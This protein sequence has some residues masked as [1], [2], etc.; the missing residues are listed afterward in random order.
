MVTAMVICGHIDFIRPVLHYIL[1]DLS[2]SLASGGIYW[3]VKY[4]HIHMPM[5]N[6]LLEHFELIVL[7][8]RAVGKKAQRFSCKSVCTIE[9]FWINSISININL[10][11]D[12]YC[13]VIWWIIDDRNLCILMLIAFKPH[14]NLWRF[15]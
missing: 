15:P 2:V 10:F 6:V 1:W 12:S 11:Q 9:L 7:S 5:L 14:T 8:P 4:C 13:I 3:M